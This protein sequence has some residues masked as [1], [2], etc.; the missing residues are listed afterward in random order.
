MRKQLF[1]NTGYLGKKCLLNIYISFG[2]ALDIEAA[3]VFGK[4][5]A[6]KEV[7]EKLNQKTVSKTVKSKKK[8][9][10]TNIQSQEENFTEDKIH[11]NEENHESNKENI[12][13]K[14]E[15]IIEKNF[16]ILKKKI[17]YL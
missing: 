10:S 8:S 15:M 1:H 9:T 3:L 2:T 11:N 7:N 4:K 13:Y 14:D 17:S 5:I 12:N 16:N 6:E